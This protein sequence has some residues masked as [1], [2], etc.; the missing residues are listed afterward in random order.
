MEDDLIKDR[1]LFFFPTERFTIMRLALIA[2]FSFLTLFSAQADNSPLFSIN[3]TEKTRMV[4]ATGKG[5]FSGPLPR[6]CGENFANW[7]KADVTT[8]IVTNNG[9]PFL[10][11]KTTTGVGQFAAML[12]QIQA[13]CTLKVTVITRTEE[14]PLSIGIRLMGAP[15]TTYWS[16]NFTS[17]SGKEQTHYFQIQQEIKKPV[18]LFLYPAVGNT[19]VA[20]ISFSLASPEAII[21]QIQRPASTVKQ[22]FRHTRF[23]LGLPTGWSLSR[24]RTD[25]SWQADNT[26]LAEDGTKTLKLSSQEKPLVCYSEPFQTNEPKEPHTLQL[27]YRASGNWRITILGETQWNVLAS[28][29]LPTTEQWSTLSIPFQPQRIANAHCVKWEG[30]GTLQI[31]AVQAFAG[32]TPPPAAWPCEVAVRPQ[33]G[34]IARDTHIQFPEE[35]ARVRYAVLHAPAGAVLRS[36]VTDLYG[37]KTSL[38][39]QSLPPGTTEKDLD[40]SAALNIRPLGQF[41]IEVWAE[42]DGKPLSLR[43]EC[44]VTRIQR[45]KYWGKD[46]PNSPFGAHFLASEPMVK[47]MKAAGINWARLHDAGTEYSGWWMLEKEKGKWTFNDAAIDCYRKNQIK[48]FAQLGTAP[49]WASHYHT[50]GCKYMGYF[51]K[52]LRPTN[53][54]DF[55]AYVTKVVSRY[56]TQIDEY[57]VWNEPW[58]RW[59]KSAADIKFFDPKKTGADFAELTRVAYDAV[60]AVDPR[61]KVSGFN[62]ITG[63]RDWTEEVFAA[64]GFDCCDIID[65]HYYTPT[66]RCR[67]KQDGSTTQETLAPIRE[68][69]PD[70]GGKPVYMSEGQG[71]STGSSGVATRMTGLYQNI[72]PWKPETREEILRLA[73]QTCRY[74]LSLL[75]EKVAKVYLYSAHAYTA[76]AFKPSF[77][78]LV[79]PDGYPHPALAA[80]SQFAQQVEDTT[81]QKQFTLGAKGVGYRFTGKTKGCTIYAN[82][83]KEEAADLAKGRALFDLYGNPFTPETYP[84]GTLLYALGE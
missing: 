40:F 37:T 82:L 31:D 39:D 59:W 67:G 36:E 52:Y 56:R 34:E 41:R 77:Q 27:R 84:A 83:T 29:M 30:T 4:T 42:K 54:V 64:G 8:Q 3:F 61:I 49:A 78:I 20:K 47:T 43:D 38:P 2:S 44:V 32:K 5:S 13:P 9:T 6:S 51:E 1:P 21:A 79:G 7:K 65:Y 35:P 16:K 58:G 22:F 72:L 28:K 14:E 57:F 53:L 12:P 81:F 24:E 71:T 76:L 10:R 15:Y 18:A 25:G 74:T 46:A 75:S 11:F 68:K 17:D 55:A 50:L 66:K 26:T 19:D 70:L 45:P 23:P 62:T 48:I 63:S 80:Y 33:S 60:K 69:Y 73:D